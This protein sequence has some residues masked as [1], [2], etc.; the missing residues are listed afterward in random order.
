MPGYGRRT[1]VAMCRFEIEVSVARQMSPERER[2]FE[3]L[4][5]YLDY[6]ATHVLK[7]EPDSH[8]H[9]MT[10]LKGVVANYGRSKALEG[11]RQAVNDTVESLAHRVEVAKA[12]DE[13]L[14]ANGLLGFYEVARRYAGAYRKILKRGRVKNE[15]EY[16]LVHG[17]LVDHANG[18]TDDER[19]VLAK[20][21]EDFES[22]IVSKGP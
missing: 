17:A 12:L 9:P 14:R 2:E 6:F 22:N 11:L 21:A 10:A 8:T 19:S 5:G 15:T 13:A 7:I 16:Y 3:E 4:A 20:L 18:I 1:R